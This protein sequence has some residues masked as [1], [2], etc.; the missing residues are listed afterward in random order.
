MWRAFDVM[1]VQCGEMILL[2][3]QCQFGTVRSEWRQLM[4]PWWGMVRETYFLATWP[5]PPH[6]TFSKL[7]V[8]LV[9]FVVHAPRHADVAVLFDRFTLLAHLG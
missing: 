2:W 1:W 3:S 6:S 4:N 7:Q 5:F 9:H 8:L